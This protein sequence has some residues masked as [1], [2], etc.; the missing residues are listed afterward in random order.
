MGEATMRVTRYL[1][2]AC[3]AFCAMANAADSP[4]SAKLAGGEGKGP[5]QG[6]LMLLFSGDD[7]DEPRNQI[8][9]SPKTQIAFG[10]NV[11]DWK[12]G[13]SRAI[14]ADAQGYPVEKIA[15]MKPGTYT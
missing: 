6:R 1:A 5:Q 14:V 3:L 12:R 2:G 11:E 7:R 4:F 9:L 15:E 10:M 8:D 13:D